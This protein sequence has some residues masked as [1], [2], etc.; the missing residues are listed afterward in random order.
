MS[1]L[2]S[3]KEELTEKSLIFSYGWN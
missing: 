2:K 3:R 1:F